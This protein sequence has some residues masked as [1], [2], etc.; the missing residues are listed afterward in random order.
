MTYN[1][2][3]GTVIYRSRMHAKTKR[4]F[5]IFSAGDLIAA[6]TQHV[7]EK[8]FQMVRYYGWYSNRARSERAKHQAE[9]HAPDN[10]AVQTPPR[11]CFTIDYFPSGY[12]SSLTNQYLSR[13]SRKSRLRQK[14]KFLSAVAH[15]LPKGTVE[16]SADCD[17]QM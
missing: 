11:A 13:S 4:N 9:C 10:S 2:G 16:L 6:I 1:E 3:N 12:Y 17:W 15:E 8:G 5:E 7:P 14:S